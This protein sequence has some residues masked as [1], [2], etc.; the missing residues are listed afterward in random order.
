MPSEWERLFDLAAGVVQRVAD[1][2]RLRV[3]EFTEAQAEGVWKQVE[4][5]LQSHGAQ[6]GDSL[7]LSHGFS[8]GYSA[9]RAHPMH[10]EATFRKP[11][12]SY[13]SVADEAQALVSGDG[14]VSI[15]VDFHQVG[16]QLRYSA[17]VTRRDQVLREG[18]SGD[19][20]A[21]YGAIGSYGKIKEA[22]TEVADFI[23]A[24]AP[25]LREQLLSGETA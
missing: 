1:E 11:S 21:P 6:L 13:A 9:D 19:I 23:D 12:R 25:L 5:D 16:R 24:S 14:E 2:A 20:N 17:A 18:P 4:H 3:E 8:G 7:H 22:V 10:W 15:C